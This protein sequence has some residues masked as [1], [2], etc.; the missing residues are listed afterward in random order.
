MRVCINA[1][2]REAGKE[3]KIPLQEERKKNPILVRFHQV[4]GLAEM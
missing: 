4:V 2:E 1:S 3:T